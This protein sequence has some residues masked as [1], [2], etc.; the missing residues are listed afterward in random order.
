MNLN[1]I[2]EICQN[3]MV[4]FNDHRAHHLAQ[5]SH[6]PGSGAVG[7]AEEEVVQQDGGH[8]AAQGEDGDAPFWVP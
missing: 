3:E 1:I 2:L 5:P 8:A 6:D 4:S 7:V